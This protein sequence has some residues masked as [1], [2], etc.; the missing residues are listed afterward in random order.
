L[1]NRGGITD[2]FENLKKVSY[3]QI[4]SIFHGLLFAYEKV[5]INFY[6]IEETKKLYSY[7]IEELV[8]ILYEPRNLV[9]DKSLGVD[10]N[11]KR[12]EYFLSNDELIKGLTIKKVHDKEYSIEIEE[13]LFAKDG[14]HRILK[15]SG[16]SCPYALIAAAVLT[17]VGESDQYVRL[18]E[19]EYTEDG[20]KTILKVE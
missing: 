19:S 5:F 16:G 17:N 3:P 8:P 6:G 9:V 7:I 4:G 18:G 12:L 1:S 2:N 10:E 20:S 14:V 13:C 15:M 11:I